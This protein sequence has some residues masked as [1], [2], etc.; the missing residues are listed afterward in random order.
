M[1][2]ELKELFKE[3]GG[4]IFKSCN[5]F[6]ENMPTSHA[7]G[8]ALF[9]Y[10]CRDSSMFFFCLGLAYAIIINGVCHHLLAPPIAQCCFFGDFLLNIT[11]C[12][13]LMLLA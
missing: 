13:S 1:G 11:R 5:I 2:D 7:V 9:I 3:G 6:L 8:L 4:C 10:A 12:A